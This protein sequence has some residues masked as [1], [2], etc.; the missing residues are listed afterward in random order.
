MPLGF[1]SKAP[2]DSGTPGATSVRF[3]TADCAGTHCAPGEYQMGSNNRARSACNITVTTSFSLLLQVITE[4][5]AAA[6]GSISSSSKFNSCRAM[7]RWRVSVSFASKGEEERNS[8]PRLFEV[9]AV[10]AI[11]CICSKEIS[12]G[13]ALPGSSAAICWRRVSLTWV[14][15]VVQ[16]HVPGRARSGCRPTHVP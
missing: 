9:I 4:S 11:S 8:S 12:S 5:P 13:V 1:I 2:A 3:F 6:Q 15:T 16:M 10:R 7:A 14:W